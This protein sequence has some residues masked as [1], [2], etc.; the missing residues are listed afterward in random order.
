MVDDRLGNTSYASIQI[1]TTPLV[2]TFATDSEITNDTTHIFINNSDGPPVVRL[3]ADDTS[4]ITLEGSCGAASASDNLSSVNPNDVVKIYL[5]QS[6]GSTALEDGVTYT[7]CII[8]ATDP[9]TTQV[10]AVTL[11]SFTIDNVFPTAP[12]ISSITDTAVSGLSLNND[13]QSNATDVT[14]TG[15][16]EANSEV[17]AYIDD[18]NGNKQQSSTS[19]TAGDVDPSCTDSTHGTYTLTIDPSDVDVSKSNGGQEFIFTT[20][21]TDNA[22]NESIESATVTQKIDYGVVNFDEVVTLFNNDLIYYI[23]VA[24]EGSSI[25]YLITEELD[26]DTAVVCSVEDYSSNATAYDSKTGVSKYA[27]TDGFGDENR[28]ICFE[29][30]DSSLVATYYN[31]KNAQEEASSVLSSLD[32]VTFGNN[33]GDTT[34]NIT[35]NTQPNIIIS[36]VE[37]A[38]AVE[39]YTW[40]DDTTPGI[41]VGL[42]QESE[43]TLRGVTQN[44]DSSVGDVTVSWGNNINTYTPTINNI[45]ADNELT[46]DGTYYF[47]ARI[48]DFVGNTSLFTPVTDVEIITTTTDTIILEANPNVITTTNDVNY[49]NRLN[50]EK[51]TDNDLVRLSSSSTLSNVEYTGLQS[52]ATDCATVADSEFT[53]TIPTTLATATATDGFSFIICAKA[54][55][56]HDNTVYADFGFTLDTIDPVTPTLDIPTDAAFVGLSTDSDGETTKGDITITGCAE[57]NTEVH[58]YITVDSLT[59][60]LNTFDVADDNTTGCTDDTYGYSLVISDSDLTS[61]RAGTANT[62]TVSSFDDAENESGT[63]TGFTFTIDEGVVNFN[64]IATVFNIGT[65]YYISATDDSSSISYEVTGTIVTPTPTAVC[66]DG[67]Y[68]YNNAYD[69]TT[70]VSNIV[71]NN[72][73]EEENREICFRVTDKNT[74]PNI[75][76]YNSAASI[77]TT[78]VLPSLDSVTDGNNSG[79]TTDNIT[80]NTQPNI[81]VSNVESLAAVEIY[82]WVDDSSDDGV[83]QESELILRGF[84]QN[85]DTN[86]PVVDLTVSWGKNS[87]TTPN[88]FDA[89]YAP[90]QSINTTALLDGTHYFTARVVDFVGNISPYTPVTDVEIITTTTDTITLEANPNVITTTN[91][92]N[93][94]NR[95]NE[96]KGTD[97]DLVRLSSS[98][99]LSNVEYTGLQFISTDCATPDDSEFTTTIPT[100]LATSTANDGLSFRIC[101]RADDIHHNTVYA[102]FEFTLDRTDPVNSYTKYTDRCSICWTVN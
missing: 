36:N 5:V 64:D 100:T 47:T 70:G 22:Q 10:S 38:A 48:V 44:T 51:D 24:D 58:A 6:D 55:D 35:N 7:N 86:L 90:T 74:P 75:S 9:I 76:Y 25:K 39:I 20:V 4:N 42:I 98:S 95:V 40:V 45:P 61:S 89:N 3:S 72:L 28:Q 34:D 23:Q 16:G 77:Q 93:Y 88:N 83:V 53:T 102:F 101:A 32:S 49:L 19:T 43:L 50:E 57:E 56:I 15:C 66:N 97:N 33:S 8:K 29:V 52:A 14:I 54:N 62:I 65:D 82:T 27:N 63:P 99:T 79:D 67:N 41:S 91:D 31:S 78:F 92:V 30:V 1:D 73:G 81:I 18:N 96:D 59:E 17:F 21:S 94:L 46:D 2:I 26:A 85:T 13:G 84:A 71:P 69:A 11:Q 37:G 68:S 80:N 87:N 60:K 12:V